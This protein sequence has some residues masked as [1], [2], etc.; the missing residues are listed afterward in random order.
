MKKYLLILMVLIFSFTAAFGAALD[1]LDIVKK[2][3]DILNAPGDAYIVLTM[4]LT[5]KKGNKSE[6][7]SE[8]FQKGTDKRLIRFLTP[9]DQKG[10]GFLTLPDDVMYLYLPAFKKVRQIASHVTNQNFAGTDLTYDD[11]SHFEFYKTHSAEMI[12]DEQNVYVIKLVP[13]EKKDKDYKYLF[14]YYR[15]DNFYPVKI[16][17]F[18]T[19]GN[20]W[21]FIERKDLRIID[22]YLTAMEMVIKDL[23]KDHSTVSTINEVKFD[24][25]LKEDVFTKRNLIRVR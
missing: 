10:I 24:I 9:A 22:G 11:L 2:G 17:F 8:M 23:K 6:R 19:S 12:S 25:G 18:D 4:V 20:V 14:A 7:K 5:D 13:E 1:V 16:E 21:K 15:K 3:D